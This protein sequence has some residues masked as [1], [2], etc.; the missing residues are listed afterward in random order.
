MPA[1]SKKKGGRQSAF[2]SEG[3]SEVVDALCREVQ[4]IYLQDEFPWVVGY[5][6]GKGIGGPQGSGILVGREDLVLAAYENHLNSRGTRAGV[7][8]S[9]KASKEDI[10]GL[11]TALQIFTDSDHEVTHP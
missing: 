3:L 1:T 5:S 10:V 4:E 8:R 9:A 7:G 6:G 2:A 11:V